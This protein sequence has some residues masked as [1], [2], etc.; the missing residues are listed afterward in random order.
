[1]K[2]PVVDG[3][4]PAFRRLDSKVDD[5]SGVDWVRVEQKWNRRGSVS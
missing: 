3:F 5:P 2:L 4:R 1:M